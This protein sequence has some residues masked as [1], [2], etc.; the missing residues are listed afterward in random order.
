M[1]FILK[2]FIINRLHIVFDFLL[3]YKPNKNFI[4]IISYVQ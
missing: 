4:L 3:I 2:Y 1:K